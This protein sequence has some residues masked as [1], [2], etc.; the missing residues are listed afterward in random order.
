MQAWWRCAM[1]KGYG[2][3]PAR[4]FSPCVTSAIASST[5]ISATP[6]PRRWSPSAPISSRAVAPSFSRGSRAT[7][8]PSSACRCCLCSSFCASKGSSRREADL[9][10]NPARRCHWLA[11]LAF[12]FTAPA[13]VLVGAPRHRR[14][15]PALR[16]AAREPGGS[17]GWLARTGLRGVNVTLP[18]KEAA[19]AL[20][21]R[22]TDDA[23]RIGAV[24][25]IVVGEDGRLE[26]SNTDGY[27]FLEH[28][29]ASAPFFQAGRG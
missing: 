18:H 8:S 10:A 12:P 26:G 2:I 14:G 7:T 28:L 20:V 22:A 16:G 24:N 11:H 29:R 3:I 1:V 15:L 23:R 6:A 4:P 21:A 5:N 17:A 25:T 19:L 9:R 13:R 27:G